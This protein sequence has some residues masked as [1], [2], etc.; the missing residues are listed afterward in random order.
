MGEVDLTWW[1]METKP[2][3]SKNPTSKGSSRELPAGGL[4]HL[5]PSGVMVSVWHATLHQG[6]GPDL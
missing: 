3:V 6:R 1:K 2:G 5:S 4:P